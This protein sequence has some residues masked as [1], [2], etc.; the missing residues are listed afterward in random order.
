MDFTL[1]KYD[2][3]CA[4][5]IQNDYQSLWMSDYI[6]GSQK[7]KGK[8]ILLR[9]DV[10]SRPQHALK[11][12]GIEHQHGLS[13]TYFF[14]TVG[15]LFDPDTI[16]ALHA[17]GHEIGYH[18]ETLSQTRGN[19]E[20]AVLLFGS[21]LERMRKIV[22]VKV[23][24]MHGSPLRPW[25]NRAIWEQTTPTDFDLVGEAYRDIDY[26]R[27]IYLSDT[28]RSWNPTRYNL[29]DVTG[30]SHQFHAEATD[31]LIALLGENEMEHLC[32]LTHPER[33]QD[34]K[35]AWLVQTIR[36]VAT[37]LVK[38]VLKRIYS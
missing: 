33:W 32:L 31:D 13:A 36:D 21:E 37:N 9:H 24:S 14:R 18:Y 5:L 23:A 19:I 8:I 6:A 2:A 15:E 11:I 25:D 26:E 20:K 4:A 16:Q 28:G 3:L 12:G 1:K 34:D 27:V 30:A 10:D 35:L 38:V 22:P 17:L 29:R 7:P